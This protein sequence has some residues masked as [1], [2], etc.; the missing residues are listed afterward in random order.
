MAEAFARQ[1]LQRHGLQSSY[2]I[3]SRALTDEFDPEFSPASGY[4]V[5]CLREEYALDISSHRSRRICPSE[6]ESAYAIIGVSARHLDIL[7]S[8][9][10]LSRKKLFR[11]SRDVRDPWRQDISKYLQCAHELYQLVPEVMEKVTST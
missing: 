3:L 11:F 4:A 5:E 10:P 2:K 1:W 6:V 9:F 7:S 8:M